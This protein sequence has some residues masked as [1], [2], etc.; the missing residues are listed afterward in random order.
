MFRWPRS[1]PLTQWVFDARYWSGGAQANY[2]LA[3]DDS[4]GDHGVLT[5]ED[6]GS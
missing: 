3:T 1:D 6:V 4:I 5:V 2:Y